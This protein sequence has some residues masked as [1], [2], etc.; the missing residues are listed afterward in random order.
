MCVCVVKA[1]MIR[2]DAFLFCCVLC[3]QEKKKEVLIQL[4]FAPSFPSNSRLIS[5]MRD[6]KSRLRDE[7][8]VRNSYFTG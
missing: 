1:E 3:S 7:N 8:G 4:T 6:D 2:I 5:I